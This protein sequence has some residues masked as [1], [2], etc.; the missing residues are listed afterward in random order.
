[1][2]LVICTSFPFPSTQAVAKRV[3]LFRRGFAINN[4]GC[5]VIAPLVHECSPATAS[6]F[7]RIS[8]AFSRLNRMSESISIRLAKAHAREAINAVIFYNDMSWVFQRALRFCHT[9]DIPAL[10]DCTEWHAVRPRLLLKAHFWDQL[11]F[12]R[13]FLSTVDAIIGISRFWEPVARSFG[14][15]F[16]RV[17]AMADPVEEPLKLATPVGSHDEFNLVYVGIFAPREIPGRLLEAVKLARRRGLAVRLTVVG[18]VAS[19]VYGARL[20]AQVKQ[21]NE[22]V[23]AVTFTGRIPDEQLENC[24]NAADGFVLLWDGSRESRACFAT[25]IPE[26]LLTGKPTILS[27]TPDVSDYLVDGVSA[28]LVPPE[29]TLARLVGT[30]GEL[31]QYRVRAREIGLAGRRAGESAFGHV[32]HAKRVLE[33]LKTVANE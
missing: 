10:A 16:L 29:D 22:L 13:H 9:H 6:P 28:L 12:R 33:F 23:K 14:K 31:V 32:K 27:A 19:R 5:E 30:I 26:Y 11:F 8:R 21:D 17:P 24:F 15:P 2:R 7:V 4:V 3:E 20:M 18:A 1:M 25:R